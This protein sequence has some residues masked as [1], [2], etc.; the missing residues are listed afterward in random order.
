MNRD[1]AAAPEYN[2]TEHDKITRNGHET[3]K[4]YQVSM[5]NGSPYNK[6]IALNGEPLSAEQAAEQNR[7]E[8]QE[9]ERRRKESPEAREKRIAKYKKERRQ[10]HELM[11]EMTKAFNFTLAGEEVVD[12]HRCFVLNATPRPGYEP[13][14]RDTQVLLGM[15]G[16]MWIDAKQYQWVKVHAEVFRPVNFGFFFASVKPGTQFSLEQEPISGNLW[17]P[18]HFSMQLRARIF[19]ES[20]HSI[21]DETYTNYQPAAQEQAARQ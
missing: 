13:P 1:W 4:T 15:R 19:I 3:D 11:T 18:S 16:K 10:D 2:F 5:I 21:D 20:R 7:K 6:L 17:L 14:N 12:G 8:Q 9:V